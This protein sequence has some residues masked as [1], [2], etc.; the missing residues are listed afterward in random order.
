MS[1]F[2]T[3]I[4]SQTVDNSQ[5]LKIVN[6]RI[7]TFALEISKVINKINQCGIDKQKK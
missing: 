4:L 2:S 6:A 1:S 7:I 5:L 3:F